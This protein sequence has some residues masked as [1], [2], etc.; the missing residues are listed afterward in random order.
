M[1]RRLTPNKSGP[2]PL[3]RALF[4]FPVALPESI[5]TG[6]PGEGLPYPVY[7][8]YAW[9]RPFSVALGRVHVP[10]TMTP[11]TL[12]PRAIILDLPAHAAATCAAR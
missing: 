10:L 3:A 9:L 5:A 1:D 2:A 4:V 11:V 6:Y 7:C 8:L 12:S